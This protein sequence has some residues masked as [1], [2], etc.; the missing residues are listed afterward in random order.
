MVE[1][2]LKKFKFI[3][4]RPI[5]FYL[6]CLLIIFPLINWPLFLKNSQDQT[7]N[8]LAPPI[9]YFKDFAD[10]QGPLDKFKLNQCIVYHQKVVEYY[11]FERPAAYAMLGYCNALLGNTEKAIKAYEASV[12][13]NPNDSWPF[14]NLGI[15]NYHKKNYSDA[16]YDFQQAISKNVKLNIF[17]LYD[18]KVYA[19]IRFSDHSR[20]GYNFLEA[21]MQGREVAY[22]G[23]MESFFKMGD[24]D[25]IFEVAVLALQEKLGDMSIFYYYAGRAAFYQKSYEKA[26]DL[27]QMALKINPQN[28]DALN[29]LGMCMHVAGKKDL[30]EKFF[31]AA[32]EIYQSQGSAIEKKLNSPVRFF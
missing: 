2:L 17:V 18:S 20:I 24:F 29:Y 14:Y 25:K 1:S 30:E 21:L 32:K 31:N 26:V 28:P 5:F 10:N 19:D 27:L 4:A 12:A 11:P 13:L 23:L 15:L 16:I 9:N 6:V 7:M 8:R 3:I 22:I